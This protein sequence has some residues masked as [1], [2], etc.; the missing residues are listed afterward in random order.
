MQVK[1]LLL[2]CA[3]ACSIPVLAQ[4]SAGAKK[5]NPN[6]TRLELL[7]RKAE[8][9]SY[10]GTGT[11]SRSYFMNFPYLHVNDEKPFPVDKRAENLRNYF[12]K[13]WAAEE[14]LDL[15][16]AEMRKARLK[17]Y[18]GAGLGTAL[19]FSTLF[20]VVGE[21]QEKFFFPKFAMSVAV[22]GVGIGLARS[23]ARRAEDHLR[24]SVDLYNQSCYKQ[25]PEDSLKLVRS[26]EEAATRAAGNIS[27]SPLRPSERK[28]LEDTVLYTLERND[29]ANSGMF[30]LAIHPVV[31]DAASNNIN[32]GL[33][34]GLFYSYKSKLR[35]SVDYRRAYLDNLAGQR[36]YGEP[37]GV[38][39]YGVPLNYKK[40][41]NLEL[42]GRFSLKSWDKEGSYGVGLGRTKIM[43]TYANA[44]GVVKGK[45]TKA[46][47]G[48]L[49]FILDN[50]VVNA[51][52]GIDFHTNDPEFA[53]KYQNQT[54]M[55]APDNLSTSATMMKSTIISAG[56]GLSTFRDFKL[57]LVEGEFK[58]RRQQQSQGDA[59]L[60]ILYAPSVELE[61]MMYYHALSQIG[62]GHQP[63]LLDLSSSRIRKAGARLGWRAVSMPSK[64]FGMSGGVE[65]GVMPGVTMGSPANSA[66]LKF[67]WGIA[68]GGRL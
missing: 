45:V 29:P 49:G 20:S 12:S 23:H 66:Y 33:G 41:T 8:I 10:G 14:Q 11:V 36:S 44:V 28:Y 22:S 6:N 60:D 47:S 24:M 37:Y 26:R 32:I 56:I 5:K 67:T 21:N 51:D 38:E 31:L 30:G 53:Y 2:A 35:L 54:Y 39:E 18:I 15:M 64:H 16:N 59:Y 4:Q 46:I 1:T 63:Q 48:R 57:K 61:K 7:F 42:M 3:L 50:R 34:V 17:S 25:S 68:I 19:L 55:L 27:S 40:A 62:G 13:C 58:G 52:N 65:V 43:R 9:S